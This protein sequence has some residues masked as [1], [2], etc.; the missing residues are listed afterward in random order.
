MACETRR[1]AAFCVPETQGG[2]TGCS[3]PFQRLPET[4]KKEEVPYFLRTSSLVRWKGLSRALADSPQDCPPRPGRKAA[5]RAVRVPSRGSRKQQKRRGFAFPQNLFFGA[6]EGTLPRPCGQSAGLSAPAGTQGGRTGCSSPFRRFPETTK[7]RGF[8][9]PQNL[10]FGAAE[11]SAS[12]LLR[13]DSIGTPTG[14]SSC[15]IPIGTRNSVSSF[16]YNYGEGKNLVS[17][18]LNKPCPVWKRPFSIRKMFIPMMLRK[19]AVL[20]WSL[21]RIPFCQ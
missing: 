17:T 12:E 20:H 19:P 18:W 16:V 10:F 1:L 8:A 9:F 6:L 2:R 21:C 13:G 7:K 3:S 15:L 14:S 11:H 4:T 5:G